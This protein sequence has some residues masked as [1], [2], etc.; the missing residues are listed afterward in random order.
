MYLLP[1]DLGGQQVQNKNGPKKREQN[2]FNLLILTYFSIQQQS[3]MGVKY[4]Q[5]NLNFN[6]ILTGPIIWPQICNMILL[7]QCG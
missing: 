2:T 4:Y 5:S 3:S 6:S 1:A 7:E